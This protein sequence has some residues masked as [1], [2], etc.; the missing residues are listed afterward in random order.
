MV[1]RPPSRRPGVP[2]GRGLVREPPP[3]A[4][5]RR[6][7]LAEGVEPGGDVPAPIV[8]SWRR[9]ARHGLDMD[10]PPA[11]EALSAG[12]L[13]EAR[14]RNEMLLRASRGEIEA[15]YEDARTSGGIVVL[16]D[17]DGL[18]LATVGNLDFAER[19]ARVSLRPGV[20]WGEASI[21]TNAIGTAIAESCE[22]SVRGAEHFFGAHH[23][24]S[25]SAV[26]IFDP[27]GRVIGVLDFSNSSRLVQTHTLALVRRAVEQIERRLFEGR[28]GSH[29]QIHFH[30]DPAL[31]DGPHEGLLA[32]EEDR[33]VGANRYGLNLLGLEWSALGALR[34][35]EIFDVDR[36]SLAADRPA[37]P[38][39]VRT[40]RGS[41]MFARLRPS[42][43]PSTARPEPRA[44]AAGRIEPAAIFDARVSKSLERAVRLSDNGVA[45]LVQGEIG[46]GKEIFARQIHT[47]GRRHDG[48]FV[49]VDC[50]AIEPSRIVA[51]LFGA[52]DG[53]IRRAEG[54]VLLLEAIEA[55]PLGIQA[56]LERLLTHDEG[57]GA[58]GDFAL[59]VATHCSLT[60]R[61]RQG[62]FRRDLLLAI[63]AFSVELEPLRRHPER[64]RVVADLWARVAPTAVRGRL[65]PATA[66]LLAAYDWPG[67]HRQLMATLRSLVV[68]GEAGERLDADALPSEIRAGRETLPEAPVA[69]D[70]EVGLETITLAAMQAALEAEGGNVS[71]AAR[72]LGVHRSTLYRRLFSRDRA[73]D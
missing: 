43:R 54:G 72:R 52:E 17:P 59:V 57:G 50:S 20:V 23:I 38:N 21:G 34:F 68:L 69:L 15:L 48:P 16:T 71:R 53:A 1:S 47:A 40:I 60:E 67:N 13:R 55:L 42:S 35:R 65:E 19:A 5:V 8:R 25:C 3:V 4:A 70:V 66:A 58:S 30:A 11:I 44:G 41:T 39:R 63:G 26:P 2:I 45:V 6:R 62:A 7:Y 27:A 64:A 31:L 49:T 22:I 18:I 12:Q 32:F 73:G 9:S 29:E 56:R 61:V 51:E 28:F 24:L 10:R 46:T 14:D 36:T 33:L 37:G